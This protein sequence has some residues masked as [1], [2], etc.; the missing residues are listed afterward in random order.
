MSLEVVMV[1][2]NVQCLLSAYTHSL[3]LFLQEAQLSKSKMLRVTESQVTQGHS[4]S[5]YYFV[6]TMSVSCT[7][8]EIFSVK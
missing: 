7:V 5:V 6:A 4:R 1:T 8:S 3:N 2:V